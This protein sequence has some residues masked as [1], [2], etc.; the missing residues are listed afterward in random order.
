[1]VGHLKDV[2]GQDVGPVD[3]PAF[4]RRLD[5][6]CQQE[7]NRTVGQPDDDPIVVGVGLPR[8]LRGAGRHPG[9]Q[10]FQRDSSSEDDLVALI[11]VDGG[12]FLPPQL[13]CHWAYIDAARDSFPS[14]TPP[15]R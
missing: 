4:S 14:N 10:H 13:G 15:M 1:M 3:Q 9:V 5:I 7:A 12:D 8:R 11:Y 2:A 6:R